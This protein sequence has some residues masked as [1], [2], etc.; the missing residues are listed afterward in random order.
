MSVKIW[1]KITQGIEATIS[2]KDSDMIGLVT[3]GDKNS[4]ENVWGRGGIFPEE[5]LPSKK[6]LTHGG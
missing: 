5:F 3:R 4:L 2:I 6:S 1:H